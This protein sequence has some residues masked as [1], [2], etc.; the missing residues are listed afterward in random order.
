MDDFEG[1]GEVPTMWLLNQSPGASVS[2]TP[3]T[4]SRATSRLALHV[5]SGAAGADV[6]MHHHIDWTQRFAGLRF[7][8]RTDAPAG[9]EV[10]VAVTGKVTESHGVALA[11]GRPWLMARV[12][13]GVEW[14]Q[15]T[16]AFDT[17]APEGP[18]APQATFTDGVG[19]LHFLLPD[20]GASGVWLDDVELL[21]NAPGC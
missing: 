21:C 7:W 9:T 14:A 2:E 19:M 12:P 5:T 16:V 18:G 11:A 4:P 17:L 8:V 3:S 15:V 6:F 10:A 20:V 1:G 13:A